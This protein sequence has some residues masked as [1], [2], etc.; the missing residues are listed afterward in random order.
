MTVLSK[1]PALRALHDDLAQLAAGERVAVGMTEA[2]R[3]GR[4]AGVYKVCVPWVGDFWLTGPQ[5]AVVQELTEALGSRSQDIDERVLVGIA[6]ATGRKLRDVF[7]G[8]EG[9]EQLVVR[10][11]RAGTYRLAAPPEAAGEADV[12][13]VPDED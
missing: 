5:R 11:K 8:V 2:A 7:T 3:R 6:G 12:A 10:G 4:T 13:R 1:L 9:W